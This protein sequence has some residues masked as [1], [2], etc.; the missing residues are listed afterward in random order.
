MHNQTSSF[1][2]IFL[3][4]QLH[5]VFLFFRPYQE[6]VVSLVSLMLDTGL[7]CFRGQTIKLLRGRFAPQ[8]NEREAANFILK[9]V[10]D[11]YLNWRGKTYDMIQYYQNKIPYW[12]ISPG[13]L[14]TN[15]FVSKLVEIWTMLSESHT[16]VGWSVGLTRSLMSIHWN[17]RSNHYWVDTQGR[18]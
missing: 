15:H 14:T 9:V 1:D 12:A 2:C 6:A 13:C 4:V 17:R 11:C 10:R 18:L 3:L 8:F 16:P 7:P 5:N